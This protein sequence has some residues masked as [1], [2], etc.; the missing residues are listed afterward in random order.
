MAHETSIVI[1]FIIQP[2]QTNIDPGK[3]IEFQRI[4]MQV[5][6]NKSALEI[7]KEFKLCTKGEL[8]TE[9]VSAMC[10]LLNIIPF[11]YA[12][13]M[14]SVY[15]AGELIDEEYVNFDSSKVVGLFQENAKLVTAVSL[16]ANIANSLS[17]PHL[18]LNTFKSLLAVGIAGNIS[19][20]QLDDA[21]NS[22]SSA[23]APAKPEADKKDAKKDA[24]K[25]PEPEPVEEAMDL[26]DMFG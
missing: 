20:K 11:E 25:E 24:K 15:I 5:K 10:R 16:E 6:T 22:K 18:V 26:G 12:M 13:K 9:T 1:E 19:F 23:P 2:Q 17:I 7:V 21:L 3:I 4:G 14:K 8:V